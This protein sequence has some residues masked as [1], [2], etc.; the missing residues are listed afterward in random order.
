[1]VMC[2]FI[3]IYSKNKVR[4][5]NKVEITPY[6]RERGPDEYNKYESNNLII[7]H[8]RLTLT[9]SSE[10]QPYRGN[11]QTI[12][13]FNGEIYNYKSICNKHQQSEVAVINHLLSEDIK[14]V[15]LFD[16][17][18]AIAHYQNNKLFLIS[19]EN[20]EKPIFLAQNGDQLFFGSDFQWVKEASGLGIS[21]DD[22]ND[23][24]Q[25][26]F[27]SLNNCSK[28]FVAKVQPA[29]ILEIDGDTI[30]ESKHSFRHDATECFKDLFMS[31]IEKRIH[32]NSAVLF[33]GGLDST[34][35]ICGL[36]LL[37]KKM[38]VYS[39]VPVQNNE[40]EQFLSLSKKLDLEVIPIEIEHINVDKDYILDSINIP[41]AD[42]SFIASLFLYKKIKD[43]GFRVVL[44]GDGADEL[45]LGYTRHIALSSSKTKFAL[46]LINKF[47][48]IAKFLSND[49]LKTIFQ[50]KD[51]G[52]MF[53]SEF[54]KAK[55]FVKHDFNNFF[56][57]LVEYDR[58]YYLPHNCC[59]KVD[60]ASALNHIEVRLP[61]LDP[62]LRKFAFGLEANELV[63]N[64]IT[65]K[66][67]RDFVKNEFGLDVKGKFGFDYANLIFK[68]KSHFKEHVAWK[69][70]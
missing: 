23:I 30:S 70:K 43:D 45:F 22:I 15:E 52:D 20:L 25:K 49:R 60:N 54:S 48:Q 66:P 38:P 58:E 47:P 36:K 35:I 64:G 65:K 18:Y 63:L 24:E 68:S 2:G 27:A 14:N 33:S 8:S 50:N 13:A 10:I 5:P 41:N 34:A 31:S 69:L 28:S 12:T 4:S 51:F 53:F 62:Y 42:I 57:R 39:V 29:T 56:K 44:G 55:P 16:G 11:N 26:S 61:F 67:V 17:F 7:L 3:G 21:Q 37:G 40:R 32:S 59:A 1:M 9:H 46:N 19:D 6:L